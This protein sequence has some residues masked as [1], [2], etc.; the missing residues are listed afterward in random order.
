MFPPDRRIKPGVQDQTEFFTSQLQTAADDPNS[1]YIVAIDTAND[2]QETIVG[3]AL[4][5]PPCPTPRKENEKK[6]EET[7]P[8]QPAKNFNGHAKEPERPQI[9]SCIDMDAVAR[10]NKAVSELLEEAKPSFKG[11]SKETMWSET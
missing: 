10:G 2:G 6:Q 1:V 7:N 5:M 11:K 3:Y 9:P 8:T 4:W